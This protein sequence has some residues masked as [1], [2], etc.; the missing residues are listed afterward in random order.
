NK[1]CTYFCK[2]KI[3]EQPLLL[4]KSSPQ[5]S[6]RCTHGTPQVCVDLADAPGCFCRTTPRR[7]PNTQDKSHLDDLYKAKAISEFTISDLFH[8]LVNAQQCRR[9]MT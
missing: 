1:N 3:L 6:F 8:R 5:W 9:T 4:S 7:P 2:Y